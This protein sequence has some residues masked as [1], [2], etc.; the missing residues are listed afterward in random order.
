MSTAGNLIGQVLEDRY[1]IRQLIGSGGMGAVYE[2]EAIRLG[3]LCAV[4]VLLPEFTRSEQAVQRFRREAHVAARVKHPNV[5]EIFDTGTTGDGSGYI[6]M[7]LLT[8]ESL[9]RTLRR[10]GKLPWPRVQHMAVQM[11]R[12]LAAAHAERI[13]HRDMKPENCFRVRRDGDDDTIKLLDFGIAKLTDAEPSAEAPRLTATNSVVGTY[14]YMAFEQVAGRDCD[15]RVDLWAVGVMLYEMLTGF[16]PFRGQNQGQIWTAIFQ[17]EPAA[18]QDLAPDASIPDAAE[19][20]VRKA[21]QKDRNL[22]FSSA[23]E[24][25]QAI[26]AAPA[27][28][29]SAPRPDDPTLRR[30]K[31]P[32]ID[33]EAATAAGLTDVARSDL[34]RRNQTTEPVDPRALTAQ[35]ADESADTEEG[36]QTLQFAPPT[37]RP[38]RLATARPERLATELAPLLSAPQQRPLIEPPMPPRRRVSRRALLFLGGLGAPAIVLAVALSGRSPALEQPESAPTLAPSR[39]PS[40]EPALAVPPSP[41]SLPPVTLVDEP[42]LPELDPPSDPPSEAKDQPERPTKKS[43]PKKATTP[44]TPPQEPFARR[45]A[46]EMARVKTRVK[47][48]CKLLLPVSVA[49]EVSAA[50]GRVTK[51]QTV[52]LSRGSTLAKCVET[53]VKAYLFPRGTADEPGY[54][55]TVQ[56]GGI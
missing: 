28:T 27:G 34:I 55:N 25:A 32:A 14:A 9:D 47:V 50:T 12:A 40:Q 17:D 4:K 23:E 44:I 31:R 49:I 33:V 43:K 48:N 26:L 16:L 6:A 21:L 35:V 51:A 45:V 52:G 41:I 24:L 30:T 11:C 29:S 53:E 8:G 2:A 5:V 10:E 1:R 36:G 38:E 54:S 15:H 39:A 22:R 20:I 18:M 42:K 13:V 3:R 7:E 46:V 19:A 56:F 37:A